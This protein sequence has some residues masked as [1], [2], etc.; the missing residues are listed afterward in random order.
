LK[1]TLDPGHIGGT[2]ARREGALFQGGYSKPVQEGDMTLLV[3]KLIAPQLRKLG[4]TVS[5]VREKNAPATEKRPNDLK[6]VSKKILL[7]AGNPEPRDN[8]EGLTI[9]RRSRRCSGITSAC[10]IATARSANEPNA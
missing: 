1:V 2:W 6:E 7:R 3:A 5:L 4:A 9:R 8:F 10:S